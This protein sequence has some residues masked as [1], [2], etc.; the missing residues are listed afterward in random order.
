VKRSTK[1]KVLLPVL[2]CGCGIERGFEKDDHEVPNQ[3][4]SRGRFSGPDENA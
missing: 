2:I 3:G 4:I 1:T